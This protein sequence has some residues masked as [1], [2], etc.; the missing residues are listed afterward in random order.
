LYV[1]GDTPTEDVLVKTGE[2]TFHGVWVVVVVVDG[3]LPNIGAT[4]G[5]F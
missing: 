1:A 2:T 5:L 3:L 4:D